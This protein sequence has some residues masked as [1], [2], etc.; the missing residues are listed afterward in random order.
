MKYRIWFEPV[1]VEVTNDRPDTIQ[2]LYHAFKQAQIKKPE[3]FSII[4]DISK[5]LPIDKD[6]FPIQQN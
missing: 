6:G 1:D 5:L 3:L 2:G 4:P